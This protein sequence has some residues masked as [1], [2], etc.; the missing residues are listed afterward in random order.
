MSLTS[1]SKDTYNSTPNKYSFKPHYIKLVL[2][3][4]IYIRTR[5]DSFQIT[6][7]WSK[8]IWHWRTYTT[9]AKKRSEVDRI[10]IGQFK[11]CFGYQFMSPWRLK[12]LETWIFSLTVIVASWLG[13]SNYVCGWSHVNGLL[14]FLW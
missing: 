7:R 13:F 11:F 2:T 4:R 14:K 5:W 1:L 3:W 6:N 8:F 9:H 12:T 10:N